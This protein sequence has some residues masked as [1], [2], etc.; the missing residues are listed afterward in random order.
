MISL[1]KAELYKIFKDKSILICLLLISVMSIMMASIFKIAIMIGP[2]G[3]EGIDEL[4]GILD[5]SGRGV[6]YNS[7]SIMNN[8][9]IIILVAIP[10][11]VCKDFSYGTIRNVILVG[12][13]KR[14]IYFSKLFSGLL[15]GLG[16]ALINI[17]I[18]TIISLLL[19]DYGSPLTITEL[20]NVLRDIGLY[21]LIIAWVTSL[22]LMFS[23]IF[24]NSIFAVLCTVGI[25]MLFGIL[26]Y[27]E[28]G[29]GSS[30]VGDILSF[31]PPY[32]VNK[33]M[34]LKTNEFIIKIIISNVVLIIVNIVSTI[35]IFKKSDIK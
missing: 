2:D 28:M 32:Q 15:V 8:A 7:M 20:L 5:L 14:N 16:L 4:E 17:I 26:S 18:S 21:L 13:K 12:H 10:L 35:F 3:M 1:I 19:M 23:F 34:S 31:L 27:L 22:C 11:F 29:G 30:I 25:I 33:L 6:I 24:K 9:G